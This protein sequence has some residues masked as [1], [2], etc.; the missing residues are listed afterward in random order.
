M[1]RIDTVHSRFGLAFTGVVEIIASTI[2]SVSVCALWGF[3]ITM[4]P[5][6]ILPVMIVFIG[7]ED[8]FILVRSSD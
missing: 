2:T 4:V 6:A 1:R 3:R 5:W 8:M 7:A